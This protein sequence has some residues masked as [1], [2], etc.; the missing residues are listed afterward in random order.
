MFPENVRELISD[1]YE[2]AVNNGDVKL[3][4]ATS[5][6]FKDS[7]T[8]MQY[9]V[10]LAP[11]LGEKIKS[12][13]ESKED[14]FARPAEELTVLADVAENYQLLLNKF[15]VVPEH[16]LLVTKEFQDQSSALTPK[17]LMMAY[18]LVVKMD[19]EDE[20]LKHLL[21][22]N[23]GPSSGSSQDHKHL[24][25]MK[26][27]NNFIP[28]QEKLCSGKEH[29]LP[30]FK[31]EPLQD[32]KVS[33]AHFVLPLPESPEDV[34]EDLLAMCYISLLQRA[35]TFFQDWL[36]E[37]PDLVKS[38]NVLLT[39]SWICIVPR[40]NEGF[41]LDDQD[42]QKSNDPKLDMSVNATGYAGLILT[43]SQ[44]AFD[45]IADSPN[46]IDDLLLNC[47]FPNS[48]E[49]KPSEYNY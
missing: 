24:Q 33:F 40:S 31:T 13:E 48:S 19:D 4:E 45:K 6:K 38:Y 46:V 30:D 12:T 22:Y 16:S 32:A 29:F 28:F 10:N 49:Q 7:K 41:N 44:E 9:F 27:P 37:R 18:N 36:N 43:K 23:C 35:L 42:D 2:K 15:P 1:K 5:K 8:G 20:N 47:G 21:F 11:S 34:N 25:I 14:P 17:E 3:I 39:K 26:L